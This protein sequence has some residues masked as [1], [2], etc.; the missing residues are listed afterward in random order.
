METLKEQIA[1]TAFLDLI[2]KFLKTG[3]INPLTKEKV[4]I[5]QIG[6]P[7]GGILSPILCNIILHRFDKFMEEYIKNFEKGKLRKA[8]PAYQKI[9]YLKKTAKTLK[10]KRKYLNLMRQIPARD[11]NDPNFKRMYYIRYADDFIILV[12]GNI[13]D[14]K[15][16]KIRVRDALKRL[17]GAE[18]NNEK[19]LV[20][21]MKDGFEFLGAQIRKLI[22][23]PEFIG[24]YGRGSN[25]KI[26][27]GRLLLNAPIIKILGSLKKAGFVKRVDSNKW[28][29]TGVK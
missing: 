22:R 3:Y 6:I 7:Q 10:E 26:Y 15:L 25:T 27:E 11:P 8:N 24:R 20:T 21:N 17:C 1:D 29:A 13:N 12:T 18:L 16:T 4:E 5:N 28:R 9:Q 14:A 19:T 2:K 23:N